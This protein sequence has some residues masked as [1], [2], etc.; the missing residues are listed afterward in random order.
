MYRRAPLL[1]DSVGVCSI[2]YL[3]ISMLFTG[4]FL[5]V[6]RVSDIFCHPHRV[7]IISGSG[8]GWF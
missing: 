8:Y 4:S 2:L 6:S 7:Y 1:S 3:W 5:V